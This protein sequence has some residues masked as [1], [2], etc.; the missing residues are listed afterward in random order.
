MNS[1]WYILQTMTN[2]EAKVAQAAIALLV[3]EPF[4]GRLTEVYLPTN[5]VTD[6]KKERTK[7]TF[8]GYVFLKMTY[9]QELWHALRNK[10]KGTQLLGAAGKPRVVEEAEIARIKKT[11]D[12]VLKPVV[13][14]KDGDQVLIL[15]GSFKDFS[16]VVRG[17]DVAKGKVKVGVLIFS[18]E[19][20][21]ELPIN[22]LEKTGD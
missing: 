4:V 15:A 22:D 9:D 21:V 17:L 16:G 13:N 18:R 8:P 12:G 10:I 19:T 11:I 14:L 5:K 20:I 1:Q 3:E 6:G 2:R 7:T